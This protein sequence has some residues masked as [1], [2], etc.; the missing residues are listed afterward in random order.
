MKTISLVYNLD[1]RPKFLD[2]MTTT[3][4]A[5]GGCRCIDFFTHGLLNKMEFF[6]PHELEVIVYVDVHEPIPD[7]VLELFEKM[8]RDGMIHKLVMKPH[9][10]ERFGQAYGKHNNDLIY[11]KSLSLATGDYVA[12]FD[13]DIVAYKRPEWDAFNEYAN[14][15]ERYAYVS[16]PSLFTPDCLDFNDPM[17]RHM[18]YV[19]ASTRFFICKRETLPPL[20]EM[21]RC[22]DNRYLKVT[23]GTTAKPNCLEHILGVI[24]GNGNV[25]YPPM[26]LYHYLLVSWAAYW[27]G[28]IEKLNSMPYDQIHDYF[29]NSCGGIH[30]AND[31]VGQPLMEE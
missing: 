24:A 9:T 2:T 25:F 3:A 7:D 14:W 4:D 26:N 6:F 20:E 31:V 1:S 19:W 18:D 28:T 29:L 15:L 8:K 17:W 21:L 27:R 5:D 11:A 30:G 22:F 16:I 10:P 13:S 12:H 23:Y